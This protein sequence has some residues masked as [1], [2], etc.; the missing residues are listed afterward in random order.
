M[1]NL[2]DKKIVIMGAGTRGKRLLRFCRNKGLRVLG[3]IDND[4]KK[5]GG[6]GQIKCYPVDQF[7]N[8]DNEVIVLV[9]PENSAELER[10]LKKKYTHV[11]GESVFNM[12]GCLP[13]SASYKKLFPLGHFYNLYPDVSEVKKKSSFLY[14]EQKE[15]PGIDL[16][17]DGQKKWLYKM[18]TKYKNV[19][20]W[21]STGRYRAEY[22]NVSLSPGDMIGLCTMLQLVRPQRLIEVGSGW[23]S[24]VILDTNE[25][26]LNDSI[27][28]SFIEPYPELLQSLLKEGDRIELHIKGLEE[29]EISY[30]TQLEEGDIL[31]IDSSHV[32]KMGSDVNYLFFEI[33]PRLKKGVYVHLHDIFYPFEYPMDWIENGM[34]W[35]EMYILRSFLQYNHEWEIVFFQN[36]M[37]KKYPDIFL[38]EWPTKL[39]IHGGSFW[40]KKV[41]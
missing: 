22:G 35:N 17:E 31:F 18:R 29:V 21:T 20:D 23:S 6:G 39:P 12:I 28:C 10:Q 38:K 41:Q 5:W 26:L 14:D 33:L 25:T 27:K 1:W 16:N 11:F 30:F 13:E 2:K 4:Q 40:M 8:M 24:G 37:E 9:S 32:S 36:M 19:P 34:V 3:F 7:L 15:L